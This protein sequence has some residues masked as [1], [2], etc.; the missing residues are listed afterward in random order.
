MRLVVNIKAERWHVSC[1]HTN[2]SIRG[3]KSSRLCEVAKLVIV[4][5]L[6]VFLV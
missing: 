3:L 4:Q 1:S 5:T 6:Q 2:Q